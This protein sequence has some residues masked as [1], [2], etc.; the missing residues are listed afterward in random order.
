[1]NTKFG[2][3]S[4]HV[5]IAS[6]IIVAGSYGTMGPA[7][8]AE[9]DEK[10]TLALKPRVCTIDRDAEQCETTVRADWRSDR[11][12]SLCL[13]IVG[14]PDVKRCW[15]N[16]SEGRYSIE[17]AFAEDLIVQLRDASLDNVLA[18][19]AIAVIRE[20]IQLRRKRKQPWNV[21]D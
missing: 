16:F 7:R 15:E 13:I 14:R 3:R 6:L 20:A 2:M 10:I 4:V 18:S 5:T 11:N 1:M 8:A 17:L 21:F 9:N 19:A 12:E